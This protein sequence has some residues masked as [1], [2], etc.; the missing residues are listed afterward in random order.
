[1]AGGCAWW[2]G[3]CV[4]GGICGGGGGGRGACMAGGICVTGNVATAADG[5][6]PGMHSC[7]FPIFCRKLNEIKQS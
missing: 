1:M 4:T 2:G 6:H 3:A 7:F 5:T